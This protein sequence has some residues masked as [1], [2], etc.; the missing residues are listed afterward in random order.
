MPGV[1]DR[2]VMTG[3]VG[4]VSIMA[5]Q[6]GAVITDGVECC[7]TYNCCTEFTV[8][9]GAVLETAIGSSINMTVFTVAA[10]GHGFHITRAV[11]ISTLGC[12]GGYQV[13]MGISR[14]RLEVDVIVVRRGLAVTICT[15]AGNTLC[16]TGSIC[17]GCIDQSTV[18][19][20]IMT[21]LAI[22]MDCCLDDTAV[23]VS[24]TVGCAGQHAGMRVGSTSGVNRGRA[25]KF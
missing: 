2:S 5:Y 3:E 21:A 19:R 4:V 10:V 18:C 7:I 24:C 16:M 12:P 14:M 22:G 13:R 23:A 17:Q 15:A 11:T 8:D 20:G 6:A 1:S 25:V 9:F